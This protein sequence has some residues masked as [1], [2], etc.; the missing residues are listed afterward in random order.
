M[1][2][3][4]FEKRRDRTDAVGG[5]AFRFD[6]PTCARPPEEPADAPGIPLVASGRPL[7]P[8][9]EQNEGSIEREFDSAMQENISVFVLKLKQ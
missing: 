2:A 8:V 1:Q 3:C 6:S 9:R 7:T 4:I 5:N